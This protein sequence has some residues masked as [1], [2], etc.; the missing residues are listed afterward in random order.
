[1]RSYGEYNFRNLGA[2]SDKYDETKTFQKLCPGGYKLGVYL[3]KV[4]GLIFLLGIDNSDINPLH[5]NFR[6]NKS[7]SKSSEQG[8]F[9]CQEQFLTSKTRALERLGIW[10]LRPYEAGK[11]TTWC[12]GALDT[13]WHTQ[14]ISL[15]P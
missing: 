12:R 11:K 1:M 2:I 4:A 5:L 10:I 8:S 3:G 14:C 13:N 9:Q 7:S 6:I 15:S